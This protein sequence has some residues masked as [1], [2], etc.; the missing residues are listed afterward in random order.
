MFTKAKNIDTAFRQSR[1]LAL[2]ALTGSIILCCFTVY[3]SHKMVSQIQ[4]KIYIL[5]NGKA[6]EAYAEERKDNVPVEA[7]DHVKTFHRLFFTLSPDDKLIRENIGKSLYLADASAKQEFDNLT[8]KGFYTSIVS[9][10]ISQQIT[11]DSVQVNTDQYPYYF[12]CQARQYITRTTSTV[13]RSLVT[14]GYLR[15]V[16]RSDNNP[17]GFLI[18]H[19]RTIENRDIKIENR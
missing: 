1:L 19:W 12:R 4:G 5:A 7:R 3:H 11:V 10:N 18:E 6:L 17:H 13:S 2:A 15:S 16:P 9:G 14:E 8:E